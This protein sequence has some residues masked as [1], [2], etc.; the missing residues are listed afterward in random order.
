MIPL[1]MVLIEDS[2]DE[3]FILF[4]GYLVFD[5]ILVL[6]NPKKQISIIT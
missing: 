3:S 1:T 4:L 5:Y 6:H 2:I